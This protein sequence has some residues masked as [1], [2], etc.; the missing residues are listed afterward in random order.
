MSGAA[1]RTRLRQVAN[2]LVPVFGG[3]I[4]SCLGECCT[5]L[6]HL[7]MTPLER[8]WPK[9][10][11]DKT[12]KKSHVIEP[13]CGRSANVRFF[14]TQPKFIKDGGLVQCTLLLSSCCLIVVDDLSQATQ[15]EL[16]SPHP[17]G[18]ENFEV[19]NYIFMKYI[20]ISWFHIWFHIWLW[21]HD[22]PPKT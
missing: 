6:C 4:L 13:N 3:L 8:C 18:P 15:H 9:K 10:S 2:C 22:L 17:W 20:E 14:N 5:I 12:Q 1:L 21:F 16:V 19:M 11:Q 7:F